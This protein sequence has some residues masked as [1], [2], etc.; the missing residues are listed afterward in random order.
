MSLCDAHQLRRFAEKAQR[1]G[2]LEEA[3]E[4]HKKAAEILTRNISDIINTKAKESVELQLE[5]HL[6][7]Q[8]LLLEYRSKVDKIEAQLRK[9]RLMMA[10]DNKKKITMDK[11]ALEEEKELQKSITET[12]AETENILERMR[13][14]PKSERVTMEELGVANSHLRHMVQDLFDE[15]NYCQK[16]NKEL[17]QR[18]KELEEELA[19]AKKQ[20]RR[21]DEAGCEIELPELTPL[22]VPAF[23][24]S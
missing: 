4:N 22:D 21:N 1:K 6:R 14:L 18:I 16:E 5:F 3:I 13:K 2:R 19:L 8:R 11:K 24:L 9:S 7:E 10:A 12:F 15:L 20:Q 17:K 23:N